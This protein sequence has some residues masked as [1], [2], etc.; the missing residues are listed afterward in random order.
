MKTLYDLWTVILPEGYAVVLADLKRAYDV[1]VVRR[2]DDETLLNDGL[3]W[4]VSSL[5]LLESPRVSKLFG[6]QMLLKSVRWNICPSLF[7]PCKCPV[8]V[9]VSKALE[10]VNRRR[11]RLSPKL[12]SSAV[13]TLTMSRWCCPRDVEFIL[14]T[15]ILQLL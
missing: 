1:V 9:S 8:R 12:H 14:M 13:L 2:K 5:L 4:W 11:V 10:K 15:P 6:S 7:L 3:V